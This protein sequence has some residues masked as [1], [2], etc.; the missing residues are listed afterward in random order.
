MTKAKS[1]E[2]NA[3]LLEHEMTVVIS[4]NSG[5]VGL[6]PAP[7]AEGKRRFTGQEP[8]TS[9]TLLAGWICAWPHGGKGWSYHPHPRLKELNALLPIYADLPA[10]RVE[11]MRWVLERSAIDPRH[12]ALHKPLTRI[13]DAM[14]AR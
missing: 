1:A 9:E 3:L 14:A 12:A 6:K 8:A 4:R 5:T 7:H 13:A 2:R 10:Q 11:T